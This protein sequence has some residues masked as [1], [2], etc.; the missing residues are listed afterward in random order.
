MNIYVHVFLQKY[1]FISLG[2]ISKEGIV[3]SLVGICLALIGI[4]EQ[5]SVVLVPIYTPTKHL[6]VLV[7][8]HLYQ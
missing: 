8:S 6:N 7:T 1:V 2:K 4:A 3:G 5:F